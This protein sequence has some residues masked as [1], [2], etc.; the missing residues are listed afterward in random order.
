M[1]YLVYSWRILIDMMKINVVCGGTSDERDVS[2]R[3]GNAV[4]EALRQKGHAVEIL[5]T[6]DS[7]ARIVRCD[8]VFPVLHG[9]GG[10]DGQF[11]ARLEKTGVPFVGSGSE[12]SR[13]CM[14]KSLYRQA[15]QAA[16]FLMAEGRV[17][18][19]EGYTNDPLAKQPHVLKPI[20]GGSSVDTLIVRDPRSIDR[21]LVR[22]MYSRHRTMLLEQLITGTEVTV[23]VLADN[24]LPVIEIIPPSDEEFDYKNKYNGKTQELCPPEHV[25][26]ALQE[27]A[28]ALTLRVHT[29]LGCR[30]LSRTDFIIEQDSN[31]LY[32]LETNTIP[33]MTG[34]SLYPKMAA[35]AG[36]DFESLCDQLAEM[37]LLR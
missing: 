5:D 22:D 18:N 36:M 25:T 19:E 17:V 10:E 34:Q 9:V 35:A 20:D 31:E 3:S 32:L 12:A 16:G 23:G 6:S 11:Q 24:A 30:D 37:A 27:A 29:A 1:Y 21:Q 26:E 33:G 13:L 15:A 2:L 8:V 7:D 28:Q 4:A 14:D